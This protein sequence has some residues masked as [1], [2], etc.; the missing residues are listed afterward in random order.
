M[1]GMI[2]MTTSLSKILTNQISGQAQLHRLYWLSASIAMLGLAVALTF[3]VR[4][5]ELLPGEA[6]VS[7]WLVKNTG[8]PG[9]ILGDFLDYISTETVAP[10][11]FGAALLMAWRLWG[12]YSA[13]LLG[14]AGALTA[15]T[16]I[17]DLADRPRPTADLEWN[18]AYTGEGGFPSQHVIYA[19]LIFGL[20]AY[21]SFKHVRRPLL[22]WGMVVIF[23]GLAVLMGPGRVIDGEHWPADSIGGYFISLPLLF[24][25]I[26]IYPRGLPILQRRAPWLYRLAGGERE[27]AREV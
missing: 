21:F 16:K 24:A 4:R 14:L 10:F 9:N 23:A 6:A 18:F 17:T 11:V 15:A 13:G 19:V 20:I 1:I 22:R 2:P 27:P 3:A 7:N 5:S 8:K 12:R 25:L 26:W